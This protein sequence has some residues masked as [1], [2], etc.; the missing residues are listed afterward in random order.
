LA[1]QQRI[2]KKTNEARQAVTGNN[3]RYVLGFG[4][5]GAVLALGILWI[6]FFAG[7]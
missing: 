7:H 3:V 1:D 5:A 4:L 2:V 6:I